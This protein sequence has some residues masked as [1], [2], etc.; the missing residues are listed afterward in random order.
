MIARLVSRRILTTS[1]TLLLVTVFIGAMVSFLPSDTCQQIMGQA[2]TQ[3]LLDTCRR[4]LKL[5]Q[6]FYQSYLEWMGAF[7][8]GD[9]GKSLVSG[10]SVADLIA[11]RLSNTL[12]LAVVAALASVPLSLFFG[13]LSAVYRNTRFDRAVSASTLSAIS[14]PDFFLAYLLIFLLSGKLGLFPG[15]SNL[16]DPN[17]GLLDRLYRTVL[18]ALTLTLVTAAHMMRMTRAS[19]V[20]LMSSPFIEMAQLKGVSRFMVI[21]RH[22]LPNAIGPIVTV[23]AINV[24]YL[25]VGVVV[26]EVV[27]VYP[28]LGQLLVDAVSKRDVPVVQAVSLIFAVVFAGV[29]LAADLIA[30]TSNPRLRHPK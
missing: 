15:I 11:P 6:P 22:A 20:A 21:F 29:N 28:G 7:L 24:A 4:N 2:A 18:P 10:Q 9:M 3:E 17:M 23:V 8:T 1:V 13:V 25:F 14:L 26:V 12:F 27:F 16:S 5:D 19:I 30:F